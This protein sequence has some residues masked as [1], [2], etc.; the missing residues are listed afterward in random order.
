MRKTYVLDTNVLLHNP[1]ALFAFE[2]N[3]LVIP[4]AVIEEIDNQKKRQ[5]EIGR[6]A[7]VVS[8]HLDTLRAS[9]RLSEGVALPQGGRLTIELN[10]SDVI[11]FPQG[12]DPEKYDNRI[13]AVAYNLNLSGQEP[14]TLVTKDLNLRIK[15]DVL[16]IRAEDFYNDKVDYE[17]LYTGIGEI[18]LSGQD[19]D[20]FYKEGKL[21]F[22]N[23]SARQTSFSFSGVHDNP[24]QSA[25]ARYHHGTLWPLVHA[26]ASNWGIRALNK[27]QR[28]A[29]ELLLNDQIKVVT[30]V[31]RAGT[32]KTLLA[33]AV[34]MEKVL[35]ENVYGRLLVTRPV[36][37]DGRR[38]RL[39]ARH[40]GRK[41]Q[42]LDAADL[43]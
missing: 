31:G 36:T 9:S 10:H 30:L 3:N 5:D 33:L 15:A 37:P 40:Q 32:G 27:E 35:E 6:N 28:F 7:R 29:L 12:L 25:M 24:S 17:Q 38:F 14:V 26:E 16:G 4:F 18:Y 1:D 8:R 21:R 2:E 43:R 19:M 13:L 11:N 41:T 34:G 23:D 20:R 22:E 39:S 42:T